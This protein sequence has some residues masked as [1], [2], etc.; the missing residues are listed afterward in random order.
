MIKEEIVDL[1]S[2]TVIITAFYIQGQAYYKPLVRMSGIQSIIL[3]LL[4]TFLGIVTGV[5]DYFILAVL[6][7]VLRGVITPYVLLKMLGNKFGEREKIKGVASLLVIDLAFF[8]VAII[9]IYEF[10]IGKILP[11]QVIF[12]LALFFQGLYLITSR[13]STP[14][15]IIGYIEEENGIVM[16]G[17][18]IIPLPLL[19]EASVFLDV[20]GLVV[21]SSLLIYEKREHKPLEELK[22]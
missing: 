1:I 9:T 11:Q 16:L 8:F 20:L 17:L 15:Q 7:A 13:N 19:V 21:I 14:A 3:A 5:F 4:S 12:P 2:V 18:F 22:G 6:V 10:V